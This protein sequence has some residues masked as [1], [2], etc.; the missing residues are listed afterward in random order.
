VPG[1]EVVGSA[2][3]PYVARE[4]ILELRPDVIT[5]DIEMPRMDGLSFLAKLMRHH[6]IPVVVVSSVTPENGETALAAL[7]LG[8]VEVIPKPGSQFSVPDVRRQLARAIRAAASADVR[9]IEAHEPT[10]A[11]AS[12]LGSV[13]TTHKLIAIG[14]STGGTRALER[15]LSPIPADAPGI[16]IV[17]HMPVGFTAAFAQRLNEV[18][19]IEV[20][21]ARDGD[22]VVPGLCLIAPGDQHMLV[23]RS[24]AQMKVTV[25]KGPPVNFHRPSVDVLFHSVA[26]SIGKNAVGAILT[27]MGADGAGGL[28]AMRN[29]GAHTIAQDQQTSVVFGMPKVAIEKGAAAEVLP[30]QRISQRILAAVSDS[31]ADQPATAGAASQ[32]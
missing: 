22:R 30:L 12:Y 4:K 2:V 8:A 25:K 31:E 1:V 3:D 14:S 16:V 27:G 24:G 7:R 32:T 9:P 26:Q 15:V 28:L 23:K 6:P 29:A 20:R 18:C 13:R 10:E 21:E 11:P 17:Q 5:L 19:A